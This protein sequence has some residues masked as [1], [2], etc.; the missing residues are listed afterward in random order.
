MKTVF[1]CLGLGCDYN[2]TKKCHL[3]S[4]MI[5]I[6]RYQ[7]YQCSECHHKATNKNTL[8][9]HNGKTKEPCP[10][11]DYKASLQ[12]SLRT[13]ILSDHRGV[14]FSCPHCDYKAAQKS[15]LNT[16]RKSLHEGETYPCP[17][18]DYKARWKR[19]LP[20]HIKSKINN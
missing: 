12:T 19:D 10:E 14:T 3:Q 9:L 4:H 6:H 18:C 13:H 7:T 16:H 5:R 11:C 1:P 20:R 15:V 17:N 8:K 2:A